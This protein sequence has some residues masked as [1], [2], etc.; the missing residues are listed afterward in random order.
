MATNMASSNNNNR[1]GS[2]DPVLPTCQAVCCEGD[3][4][5]CFLFITFYILLKPCYGMLPLQPS[6]NK[7]N[8]LSAPTEMQNIYLTLRGKLG[9]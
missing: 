9:F 2:T 4:L 5:F 6:T 7:S 8:S 3:Y 1:Y